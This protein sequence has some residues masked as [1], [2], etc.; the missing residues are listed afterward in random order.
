MMNM[1][2]FKIEK[3]GRVYF[4]TDPDHPEESY[5]VQKPNGKIVCNCPDFRNAPP[6]TCDHIEA[7]R[8]HA[9]AVGE[10]CKAVG[11]ETVRPGDSEENG[12]R[13]PHSLTASQSHR[14]SADL[15]EVEKDARPARD[16]RAEKSQSF[17]V[18]A[19]SQPVLDGAS[20]VT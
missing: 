4:L 2:D 12:I 18:R 14:L 15:P 10:G 16:P 7:L 13:K 19:I 9:Q 3:K 8:E 5:K 1:Q 11:C 20:R 17:L 6:G